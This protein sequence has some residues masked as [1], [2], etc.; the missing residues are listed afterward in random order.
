MLTKE[1]AI[2]ADEAADK[3]KKE[4]ERHKAMTID[5]TGKSAK[6]RVE[7]VFI[8]YLK[9][10]GFYKGL[11][12]VDDPNCIYGVSVIENHISSDLE[13]CKKDMWRASKLTRYHEEFPDGYDIIEVGDYDLYGGFPTEEENVAHAD[14]TWKKI[15]SHIGARL[16]L[17]LLEKASKRK[18][19]QVKSDSVP[20]TAEEGAVQL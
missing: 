5:G 7:A 12:F 4:V 18:P 14:E 11:A 1:E 15:Y 3:M 17:K 16:M 9:M 2:A 6:P 10:D 13:W 8:V 20:S 19:L